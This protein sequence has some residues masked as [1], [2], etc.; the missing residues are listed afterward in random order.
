MAVRTL[1]RQLIERMRGKRPAQVQKPV[2]GK[3]ARP[4]KPATPEQDQPGIWRQ[5]ID[6]EK[7]AGGERSGYGLKRGRVKPVEERQQRKAIERGRGRDGP[8]R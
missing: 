2:P 6:L 1:I 8:G 4:D 3:D 5:K 7:A